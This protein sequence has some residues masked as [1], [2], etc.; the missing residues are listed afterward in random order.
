MM[1]NDNIDSG[2]LGVSSVPALMAKIVVYTSYGIK[3]STSLK[4]KIGDEAEVVQCLFQVSRQPFVLW[5]LCVCGC[6]RLLVCLF[7]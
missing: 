2:E 3:I 4:K 5:A 6:V 7:E 1:S